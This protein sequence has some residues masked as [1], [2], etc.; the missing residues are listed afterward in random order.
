MIV[1]QKYIVFECYCLVT[2]YS[3]E[4]KNLKITCFRYCTST[5]L[6]NSSSIDT[7]S[8]EWFNPAPLEEENGDIAEEEVAKNSIG[9]LRSSDWV[10]LMFSWWSVEEMSSNPFWWLGSARLPGAVFN[11]FW[12]VFFMSFNRCWRSLAD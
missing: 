7:E 10:R 6:L 8:N 2:S 11:S 1:Y 4:V 3:F 5:L 12:N 9:V